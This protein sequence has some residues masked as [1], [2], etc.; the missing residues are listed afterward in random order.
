M[1][2]ADFPFTSPAFAGPD[3][4]DRFG[5]ARTDPTRIDEFLADPSARVMALIG[6]RI[7]IRSNSERTSASIA[8]FEPAE[9]KQRGAL[10]DELV[11]LG[12]QLETGASLFCWSAPAGMLDKLADDP[13]FAPAVDLRSL[14]MQ[15]VLTASDLSRAATALSI[16]NWH[17]GARFC[18]HCGEGTVTADAGWKRICQSCGQQS[19]P[20]TDPVV[21]MLVTAGEYCVLGRQAHFPDGMMSALAGFVEPGESIEAA[22]AREIAEEVGLAIRDVTYVASQPWPFPHSLMIACTARAENGPLTIDR[23]ELQD[24]RW[25]SRGEAAAMLQHSHPAGLW[26]PQP[27]AI[28][29]WLVRRFASGTE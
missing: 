11:L 18:G 2:T 10:L 6:E 21:I 8:L 29:H 12:T 1:T 13:A 24:A 16:A 9:L 20:R 27:Y 22:A 19:F 7:V 25:F 14:A 5:P 23:T 28:A 17:R 15:G 3:T 4:L 26:V